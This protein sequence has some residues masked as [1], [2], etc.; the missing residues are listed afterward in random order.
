MQT[1][2]PH[3]MNALIINNQKLTRIGKDCDEKSV[4]FLGVHL[5]DHLSWNI[6]VNY[7]HRKIAQSLF[8]IYRVKN[9]FPK[10]VL[11]SLYYAL[12][13]SHLNYAIQIWG[14]SNHLYKLITQQKRAIRA[15]TN[16]PYLTHTE[17]LFKQMNILKLEDLYRRQTIIFMYEQQNNLIPSFKSLKLRKENK[18]MPT[19]QGNNVYTDRPRT[20][21]SSKLPK[22]TFPKIWNECNND[23]R[24]VRSKYILKKQVTN[25]FIDKYK[26][27]VIC[28][29][30]HCRHCK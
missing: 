16:K 15:I 3:E 27:Q 30:P 14:N 13:H 7:I 26:D 19:H 20:N 17:S 23:I 22:H 18:A 10:S 24:M 25:N 4:K 5:D 29:N 12:I 28:N 1:R 9:I 6:H 2:L 11:T 8:A 21:F